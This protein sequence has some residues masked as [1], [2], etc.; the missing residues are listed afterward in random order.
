MQNKQKKTFFRNPKFWP[1]GDFLKLGIFP[2]ENPTQKLADSLG[3]CSNGKIFQ[4]AFTDLSFL[5]R[6]SQIF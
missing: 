6:N 5:A 2:D 1:F 4:S 3:P